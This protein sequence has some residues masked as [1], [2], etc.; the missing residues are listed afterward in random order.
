MRKI[1]FLM[2]VLFFMLTGCS[3]KD[4]PNLSPDNIL[5]NALRKTQEEVEEALGV[6]LEADSL[7]G[8]PTY[9]GVFDIPHE[10]AFGDKTSSLVE[11]QFLDDKLGAAVYVFDFTDAGEAWDY[12]AEMSH[13]AAQE[14]KQSAMLEVFGQERSAFD[15]YNSYEEYAK[16]I[17]KGETISLAYDCYFIDDNTYCK[18]Q[19]EFGRYDPFRAT[20]SYEALISRSVS[21]GTEFV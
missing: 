20:I 4:P 1:F 14:G 8:S 9:A 3:G 18:Y 21:S 5:K 11:L 16:S 13:A 19:L 6:D 17:P 15:E 7:E 2:I 12:L 10:E